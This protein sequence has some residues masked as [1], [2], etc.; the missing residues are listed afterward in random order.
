MG[1]S[2]PVDPVALREEL[3]RVLRPGGWLQ[4]SDIANGKPV[5]EAA[6]PTIDLWTAGFA[7]GFPCESGQAIHREVGVEDVT[8]G[9]PCNTSGDAEGED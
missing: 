2:L 3:L 8:A 5:P 1:Q 6:T 4:F 9:S 7:G